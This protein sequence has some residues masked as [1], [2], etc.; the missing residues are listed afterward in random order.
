ML[1]NRWARLPTVRGKSSWFDARQAPRS[2]CHI[3]GLGL[4][5]TRSLFATASGDDVAS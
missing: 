1:T 3:A 4:L 2:G 5:V